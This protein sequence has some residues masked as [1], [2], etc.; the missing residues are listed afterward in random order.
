M[1]KGIKLRIYPNLEQQQQII[2]NFGACR[3]VWN[4]MLAM[5]IERY[6]NSK[7][8]KFLNGFA[9]NN[10]L[11]PLK[12]EY[13]WLKYSDSTSLQDTCQTLGET[14]KRFFKHTSKYPRFKSRKYPKQ[15]Y[16][17][18]YANNNI[19]VISN[20]YLK[21]PK[22]GY[23]KYRGYCTDK[24]IKS[25][26]IKLSPAGKFYCVLLIECESQAQ[27]DKTNKNVGLDMGV[28]DLVITSDGIKYK[29]ISFDKRLAKKKRVWERKLARRRIQAKNI[30]ATEKHM[31][32]VNARTELTDFKNY[33]K[34]KHMVA[35]YSEKVANQRRNYL[36]K[37][38]TSLV[39]EYDVIVIEDLKASN[40][41]KNHKL[42]RAI[43][44]QSWRELRIML[45]YKCEW[46]G[47]ELKVVNPYKTSQVCSNCGYDDGKHTLDIRQWTCPQCHS[48]LDRDINAS[49]NIMKLGLG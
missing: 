40:M 24:K 25:A 34:A 42:A 9:M 41:L 13:S 43:A 46:Y 19:K 21:L 1:Y 17:A 6:K 45:E 7:E 39:K 4:Q 11:K 23:I 32:L 8:A 44:N 10:L 27:F 30:I 3:F 5:Q 26:T 31:K 20:H 29:T 22:L 37:L 47:K 2:E 35:K 38:T 33:V 16:K 49:K 48:V 36:Q 18:K 14:F 28:A 12:E 15:S